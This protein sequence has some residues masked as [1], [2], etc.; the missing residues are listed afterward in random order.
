MD[1]ATAPVLENKSTLNADIVSLSKLSFWR[2]LQPI[3]FDWMAIAIAMSLSITFSTWWMYLA[4]VAV[5][6]CRQHALLIIVHEASHYRISKTTWL[7]D[8]ITQWFAAFPNFFCVVGYRANHLKHHRYL[9][10]FQDPDWARKIHLKEWQ[11]PQSGLQLIGTFLKIA[12]T[13]WYK[14]IL[15]F[16][17]LSGLGNKET[18]TNPV[19]RRVFIQKVLFYGVAGTFIWKMGWA[20]HLL[21]YWVIPFLVVLPL[22]ERVR[23]ISEHFALSYKN[24]YNQTRDILSTPIEAFFFGPHN[25]RY[26]LSHHLYPSVPQY[27]L[28]QLRER[29]L[30]E[31]DFAE[32]GHTND[33]YFM[34]EKTVLKDILSSRETL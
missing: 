31:V 20:S 3:A 32:E 25:I 5:I 15:L 33:G 1:Q 29:L 22:F 24:D 30:Q 17:S 19:L 18:Y 12:A 8:L 14:L 27:N 2:G 4:A 21:F 10:S 26:H 16:Y 13:S 23:S 7:N 11:F 6:A 28:P 9:N 34:G